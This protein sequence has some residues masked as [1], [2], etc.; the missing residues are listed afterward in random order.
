MLSIVARGL[1]LLDD[2]TSDT[3]MRSLVE[4]SGAGH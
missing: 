4:G 1:E 3:R 2:L